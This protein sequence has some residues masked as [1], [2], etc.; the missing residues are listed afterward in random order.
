MKLPPTTLGDAVW[1]RRG[2]ET[3]IRVGVIAL[4][5][6]WSLQIMRPFIEIVLWG[7][8]I[9]VAIFPAYNVLAVRLG[10]RRKLTAT[11]LVL[12]ALAALIIPSVRFLGDTIDTIG[13]IAGRMEAGTLTIPPPS[14]K[15][16]DWPIVGEDVDE[17]WRLASTNL[18]AAVSRYEPQLESIAKRLLATGAGL[19]LGVL[20][21][22][23]S[24]IIAGVFLATARSGKS[25]AVRIGRRFAGED[26]AEFAVLAEK[27]IRSVALG[28]LGIA[29]VQAILGGL[30]MVFAG[31]PGA[32]LWALLIL[33]VAIIQLPPLRVLGPVAVWVFSAQSTTTAVVFLI[34]ALLVSASDGILKPLLLGRGVDV[35]ALVILIGAIGGMIMSGII[36][37]FVGAVVL[38]LAYQLFMAWLNNDDPDTAEATAAP[39]GDPEPKTA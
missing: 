4:L 37:L 26:G 27:T 36:G 34:W 25:A 16:R 31:V 12:V 33:I 21:F 32:G 15:V 17:V 20:Q 13:D 5:V 38:A 1:T 18:E 14:D 23:I 24:I 29:T 9:A 39:L 11:L 7:V 22:I 35:P 28:V 8:I 6:L 10:N 19:G 3:A 2:V 30:G